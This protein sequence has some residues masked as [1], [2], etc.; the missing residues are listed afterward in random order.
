MVLSYRLGYKKALQCKHH[1]NKSHP[2]PRLLLL[3]ARVSWWSLMAHSSFTQIW[4]LNR[5][6][7]PLREV[8]ANSSTIILQMTTISVQ[9]PALLVEY[10]WLK[11]ALCWDSKGVCQIS[12]LT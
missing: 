6:Q 8:P 2:P 7:V 4:L 5:G 9:Q 3:Y 1:S 11:A 10:Q 12:N